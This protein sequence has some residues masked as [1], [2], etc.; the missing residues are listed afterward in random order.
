MLIMTAKLPKRKLL[1]LALVLIAVIVAVALCLGGASDDSSAHT[2]GQGATNEAR[3]S[4]LA[5]FGWQ[6]EQTPVKTQQVKVP[7]EPG[8]VF[9]RYNELQLSQ[10]YDLLQY[11]GEELTRY[12]YKITNY[13]D[14]DGTYYATLLVKDGQ[15]VG[16]DVASGAKNGVMHSLARP[17]A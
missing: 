12:V 1:I 10:G 11:S 13:P 14:A 5:G 17:E 7:E 16:A 9:L 3:L 6:V 8:E 15:I 2:G 4:F